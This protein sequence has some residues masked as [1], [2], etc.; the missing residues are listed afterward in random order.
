MDDSERVLEDVLHQLRSPLVA[1]I[2]RIGLVMPYVLRSPIE[3]DLRV[4]RGLCEKA[5]RVAANAGIY[6]QF[7][8]SAQ[9]FAARPTPITHAEMLRM[10]VESAVDAEALMD[11]RHHVSFQVD[12]SSIDVTELDADLA[13][14]TQAVQNLLD[15]AAKYSYANTVVNIRMKRT[16]RSIGIE[17]TNIGLTLRPPDHQLCLER[18]WRSEEARLVTA[19]GSGIGLWVTN[20]IMAAHNGRVEVTPTAA[21]G[22]T[23]IA[24]LFPATDGAI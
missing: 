11:P 7:H 9:E 13:L 2:S 20:H 5:S 8:S 21:D 15:N 4:I 1:A 17:V 22:L 19:E 14:V 6:A 16:R 10:L 23:R 12:R 18:G 3:K 24:L